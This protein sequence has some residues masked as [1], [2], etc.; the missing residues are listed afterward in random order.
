MT[1]STGGLFLRARRTTDFALSTATDVSTC[2]YAS[3]DPKRPRTANSGFNCRVDT[4]NGVW[5]FCPTTVI[6]ASDCG[7]AGSCV[8]AHS[9]VD[10]CGAV[11]QTDVTTFTWWVGEPNIGFQQQLTVH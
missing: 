10:G 9:C 7:L 4:V 3:G 1:N 2:G 5:G 8:D 11:D 6:A